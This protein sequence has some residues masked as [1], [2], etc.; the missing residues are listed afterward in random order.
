MSTE[1]IVPDRN[2]IFYEPNFSEFIRITRMLS[3]TTRV[4]DRAWFTI[5]DEQ[6][7]KHV[8]ACL[9]AYA[10]LNHR[11]YRIR[12]EIDDEIYYMLN[13]SEGFFSVP[14]Y[15][16]DAIREFCRPMCS[17]I[18]VYLPKID[19][20][21]GSSPIDVL[22]YDAAVSTRVRLL[23]QLLQLEPYVPIQKE[24]LPSVPLTFW[25]PERKVILSEVMPPEYRYQA[26][27]ILKS[28]VFR[29]FSFESPSPEAE[30]AQGDAP[31]SQM[32]QTIITGLVSTFTMLYNTTQVDID[33]RVSIA[34][35]QMFAQLPASRYVPL[36]CGER[37]A[38]P[39]EGGPSKTSSSIPRPKTKPSR[40]KKGPAPTTRKDP[41]DSQVDPSLTP[42]K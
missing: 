27:S 12:S 23:E 10:V 19:I 16:H 22:G 36:L 31:P 13:S 18:N 4:R 15:I 7:E 33:G 25:H 3:Q 38:F 5:T 20:P 34:G 9:K 39:C 32:V 40:K 28:C 2:I 37:I 41:T 30:P 21:A 29:E 35:R 6:A 14:K 17:G 26:M 8:L 42:D 1:D 24:D 11:E